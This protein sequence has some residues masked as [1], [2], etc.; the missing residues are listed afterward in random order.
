MLCILLN[1]IVLALSWYQ[2]PH[3]VLSFTKNANLVF[4]AIFTAEAIIKIVAY[5]CAYF[6]DPWNIFDF[7]VVVVTPIVIIISLFPALGIDAK[8]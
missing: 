1:T 5:K 7:V 6:K 3:S 2:E 4:V 8:K